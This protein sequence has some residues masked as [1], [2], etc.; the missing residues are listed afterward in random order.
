VPEIVTATNAAVI[1][2][3]KLIL[4]PFNSAPREPIDENLNAI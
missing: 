2:G 4:S 1:N 3:F